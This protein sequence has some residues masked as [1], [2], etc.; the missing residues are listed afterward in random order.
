M[1]AI[2]RHLE[3]VSE[4][5]GLGG[6][7]TPAVE[8]EVE[9]RLRQI[10]RLT[11]RN[12]FHN[13]SYTLRLPRSLERVSLSSHQR[14][15]CRR[16]LCG[17]VECLCGGELGERGQQ[18]ADFEIEP[19]DTGRLWLVFRAPTR[20]VCQNKSE[21][22]NHPNNWNG[23]TPRDGDALVFPLRTAGAEGGGS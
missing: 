20:M 8:A 22:F 4:S 21:D 17:I 19:T 23:R 10:R 3:D 2:K 18:E 7:I 13:T 12:D 5:M 14:R 9:R 11:V 15:R 16:A 1:S 6:E